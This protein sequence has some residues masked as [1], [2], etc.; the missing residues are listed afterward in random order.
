MVWWSIEKR[1]VRNESASLK[2]RRNPFE[3]DN[4]VAAFEKSCHHSQRF[5]QRKAT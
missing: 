4:S 2:G 1:L 5:L 3:E